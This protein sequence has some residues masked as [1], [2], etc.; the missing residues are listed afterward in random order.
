[1][2]I[3]VRTPELV[4]GGIDGSVLT[5]RRALRLAGLGMGG[6]GVTWLAAGCMPAPAA[7]QRRLRP[8]AG[9]E[10]LREPPVID[11]AGGRL[12]VELVAAPGIELAGVRTSA[13][14]Y[15]GSSP[16]PTLRVRPG[17]RLRVRLVNRLGRP[18]NV[19]THGL[20]VSPAGNGDNPFLAV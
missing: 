14:G 19:H 16:G 7:D 15:N 6:L 18:T 13:L 8:A 2:D 11:S 4:A 17:D 20:R 10:T 3:H 1:M 9:G 12:E 5:R